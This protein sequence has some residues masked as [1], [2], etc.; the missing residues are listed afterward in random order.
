MPEGS[1]RGWWLDSLVLAAIS[2]YLIWPWLQ[3]EWLDSFGSI[4]G[5][6]IG[7]A[8]YLRENLP[9]PEWN[10]NWYCGTRWDYIY[11]PALRYGTALLSQWLHVSTARSYHIYTG[12]LYLLGIIGVYVFSRVASRRRGWAFLTACA[13]TSVSP[14]FLFLQHFRID[15]RH[16]AVLMPLRF[17]V[18]MRYGEGP[19]M[20][21]L[22]VIGFVFAAAWLGLRGNRRMLALASFCAAFAVSNNFYGATALAILFPILAWSLWITT[23]DHHIWTRSIALA[24]L[25]YGLTAAWLTPSYLH[26]TLRNMRLVSQPGHAWSW[27]LEGAVLLV[28]A[29]VSWRIARGKPERAW[30][31]FAAGAVIRT[32]LYVIGNRYLDFRTIGEPER[33]A[34]E[35]DWTFLMAAAAIFAWMWARDVRMRIVVLALVLWGFSPARKW[36]TEGWRT[37]PAEHNY[38]KRV[39]Y[40]TTKWLHDNLPGGRFFVPASIRFWYNAWFD[41]AEIGGGSD[42]GTLN[43]NAAVAYYEITNNKDPEIPVAWLKALGADAVVVPDPESGVIYEDFIERRVFQ[44]TLPV[45][46]DDGHGLHIYRVP[47]KWPGLARIVDGARIAR[48]V[49]MD[50]GESNPDSTKAYAAAVEEHSPRPAA[51]SREATGRIR[52][53]AHLEPGEKLIVQESFDPYWRATSAGKPVPIAPDPVQLMLLDPGPGDHDITLDFAT[54]LENRVGRIVSVGTLLLVVFLIFRRPE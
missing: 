53:R 11:P 4:E 35:L 15:Y 27:A 40:R 25:A 29:L 2:A 9:H 14:A 34:P 10:P 33:L 8:R 18:L 52:V 20:S 12:I 37:I 32:G 45:L 23:R 39:E 19:H 43:L 24:I 26:Y 47:R 54:P 36:W 49:P 21:S 28:F 5:T 13:V 1:R 38:A 50:K 16:A 31:V 17:G 48:I 30:P 6:F 46:L 3:L 7:D 22:A 44:G 41:L 42:Q 51:W